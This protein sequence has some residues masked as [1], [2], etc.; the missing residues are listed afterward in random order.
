MTGSLF[1]LLRQL[2]VGIALALCAQGHAATIKV[3]GTTCGLADAI[4]A[5][6]LDQPTGGC[7]GG[8]GADQLRLVAKTY[9]LTRVDNERD[10][11][12]GLPSILSTM[13]WLDYPG[14]TT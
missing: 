12:N 5:A 6:N 9:I 2:S 11:P 3:D 10:G 8:H 4:T 13:T 7:R 1:R 14:H